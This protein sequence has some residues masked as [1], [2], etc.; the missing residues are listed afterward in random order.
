[1]IIDEDRLLSSYVGLGLVSRLGS[2]IR[3]D[4]AHEME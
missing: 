4:P 1:M 2:D 3:A